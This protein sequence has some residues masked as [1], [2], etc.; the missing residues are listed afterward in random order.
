MSSPPSVFYLA[1][2]AGMIA[3]AVASVIVWKRSKAVSWASFGP[4]SLAWLLSVG[5]KIGWAIPANPLVQKGLYATLPKWAAG[6]ILWL[7]IGL[8]TGAF[9][10]GITLL[11]VK[12]TA[13]K[14][15]DWDHAVAFGIGF[16]AIEA[17]LLG[18][19]SLIGY[20]AAIFFWDR[21]PDDV[22]VGLTPFTQLGFATIP[23]PVV[24][25]IAALVGHVA[26]C[27]LIFFAVRVR[28]YRWF[29]LAFAYKTAIDAFAAWF[30][31]GSNLSKSLGGLIG[32]EVVAIVWAALGLM[33][34]AHLK[35]R[36]QPVTAAGSASTEPS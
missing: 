11:F 30:L 13:L 22:R 1:T 16:G 27:V 28:D 35:N 33:M 9:E 2:G 7:Y 31:M 15:A 20:L 17:L 6:P 4:G 29:W 18:V 5:L 25:R 21:L 24:E 10:C 34:L 12:R 8:L 3:V 32:I 36:F 19:P 23:L 26:T 14:A